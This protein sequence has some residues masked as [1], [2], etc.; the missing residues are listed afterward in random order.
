TFYKGGSSNDPDVGLFLGATP[1]VEAF[2][3][4]DQ[5]DDDKLLA[6][7]EQSARSGGANASKM[8]ATWTKESC[9]VIAWSGRAGRCKGTLAK[10]SEHWDAL[11]YVM[12]ANKRLAFALFMAKRYDGGVQ[13]E[14]D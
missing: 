8:G 6:M 3:A 5:M 9:E 12:V 2:S 1:E 13:S 11:M 10:G 4:M 14:F 7:T